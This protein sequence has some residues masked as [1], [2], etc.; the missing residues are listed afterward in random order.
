MAGGGALKVAGFDV[1]Q[2]GYVGGFGQGRKSIFD[3][4][5]RRRWQRLDQ[6]VP[7]IAARAFAQPLRAGAATVR[8]GK[9]GFFFGH[10][11]ILLY[12]ITDTKTLNATTLL[13]S[14]SPLSLLACGKCNKAVI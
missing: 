2:H 10:S 13:R 3:R 9:N 1:R 5:F 8:T 4:A 7:G 12:E 6:R 14:P 11:Q